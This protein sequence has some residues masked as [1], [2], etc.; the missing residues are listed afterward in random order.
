MMQYAAKAPTIPIPFHKLLKVV[1][2]GDVRDRAAQ[3][4]IERLAAEK[5]E[6]EVSDR[7]D[8]DVLE[9]A[10]V[11]AKAQPMLDYFRAFEESFNRF[12]GFSYEVQGVYQEQVDGRIELHTY[13]VR[14]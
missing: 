6:V 9:D 7:Y 14:E 4:L 10:A 8:R 1:V 12:P 13:V 3:A 2:V 11:G 5:L